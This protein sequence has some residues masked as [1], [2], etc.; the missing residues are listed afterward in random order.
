MSS[1]DVK[2]I[3]DVVPIVNKAFSKMPDYVGPPLGTAGDC[4]LEVVSQCTHCGAP[5]YGRKEIN[6][7]DTPEIKY[8]CQCWR[9]QGSLV[10][11]MHTK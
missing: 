3:T 4:L 5:I 2:S 1:D 8:S 10:Q 7:S 11:E 9:R 6:P